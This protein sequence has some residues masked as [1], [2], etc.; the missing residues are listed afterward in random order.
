MARVNGTFR[1]GFFA[2]V[3]AADTALDAWLDLMNTDVGTATAV[4]I[5]VSLTVATENGGGDEY[6]Q[7]FSYSSSAATSAKAKDQVTDFVTT[8]VAAVIADSA[9]TTIDTID[10]SATCTMSN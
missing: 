1:Q 6:S 7:K 5:S 4:I 8:C 2:T 10:V 3:A 9:Y